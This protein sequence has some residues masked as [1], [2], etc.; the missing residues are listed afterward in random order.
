MQI[1]P[2]ARA[3]CFTKRP[4]TTFLHIKSFKTIKN[5]GSLREG[6]RGSGTTSR[7]APPSPCVKKGFPSADGRPAMIRKL[8]LRRGR[9]PLQASC[10]VFCRV[11]GACGELQKLSSLVGRSPAPW[12]CFL[13]RASGVVFCGLGGRAPGRCYLRW[14]VDVPKLLV[15]MYKA[16]KSIRDEGSDTRFPA[17]EG[18]L[19]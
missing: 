8:R 10:V 5:K 11:P 18:V 7:G 17:S 14:K 15:L 4:K 19:R 6:M 3:P 1:F 13:W 16:L 12:H 9:L 2:T